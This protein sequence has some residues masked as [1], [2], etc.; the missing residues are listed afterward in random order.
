MRPT[1]SVSGTFAAFQHRNYRLW[2]TGQV[3]SLIGTWMQGTAQGYF[4]YEL[5]HSA[6]YLG[7]VGFAAG[8]PSWLLMLWGGVLADRV[9]RRGLL[10]VTQACL[11][12]LAFAL[13]ALAFLHLVRP[14]HIILLAALSGIVMAFDAPARQ[15]F[16]LEL[17]RREHLTNAIALNSS[18][19]NLAMVIGPAVA[20][21]TYAYFGPAWCF[22]INGLSFIAVITALKR[23]RFAE[24]ARPK[25]EASV[26]EELQEGVRYALGHSMIRTL[27]ILIGAMTLFGFSFATLIPAWAVKILHG[28]ARVN[29]FLQSARGTG[30][31]CGALM[32]A[33]VSHARIKGKILTVGAF[34]FPALLF[35]FSFVRWL[36]LSLLT[37]FGMGLALIQVFNVANALVQ[38]LVP[39]HLRGRVMGVYSLVFFGLTPLGAPGI[40]AA[41]QALGEPEVIR[42]SAVIALAFSAMIFYLA[43]KVRALE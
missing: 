8:L 13:A 35:A 30:A 33:A 24:S 7:Y 22:M 28:D 4:V 15:S 25:S 27:I 2:F 14:W 16:V 9:P 26:L 38:S 18:M 1:L 19:F 29:G 3:V 23:M 31:L 39:D 34:A 43:P 17:V 11:M 41:A 20:G 12:A 32:I 21:I 36:P 42:V 37:L 10:I 6:A 40:G 5:T